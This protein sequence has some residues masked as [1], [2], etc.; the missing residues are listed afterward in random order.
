MIKKYIVIRRTENN[1]KNQI[2][3]VKAQLKNEGFDMNN[4]EYE[5]IKPIIMNHNDVIIQKPN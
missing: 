1:K 4:N 5:Y 2:E 3:D